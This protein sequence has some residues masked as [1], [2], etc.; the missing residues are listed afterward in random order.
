MLMDIKNE[1]NSTV[2]FTGAFLEQNTPNPVRNNT[3]IHCYIPES[4]SNAKLTLT[5]AKGQIIRTIILTNRGSANVN[6]DASMLAAG[7]YNYALYVDGKQAA[8]KQLIV[9]R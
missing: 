3:L 5:N 1:K 4:T 9:A 2:N 7:T 8:T 6:L